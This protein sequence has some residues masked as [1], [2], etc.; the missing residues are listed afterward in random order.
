MEPTTAQHRDERPPVLVVA[1]VSDPDA[2]YVG[3]RFV[4]RGFVLEPVWRD[5]AVPSAVPPEAAAVLLLGSAWSVADPVAPEALEAE[6][7]LVRS[8]TAAGVPVLGLCYGAQVLAHAFGGRV[9]TAT[10]PEVGL[11]QVETTDSS[12][13]PAGPWWEF[14]SDVIDLPPSAELLASNGCGVQAFTVPGALAVQFHPEV[15]PEVLEDWFR[16]AP[17]MLEG[18]EEPPEALVAL[19]TDREEQSRAA[20]YALVDDF[21]ARFS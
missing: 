18:V 14:H 9:R 6:C 10:T 8:A 11:V 16:R 20:A 3:D 4:E 17:F 15:R 7:A 1:N 13:V 5:K 12:L 21:L 19:A 2:G